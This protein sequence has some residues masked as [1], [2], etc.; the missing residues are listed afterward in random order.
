MIVADTNLIAYLLIPGQKTA[1]AQ[2]VF[3]QDPAWIAPFLWRS[4]FRNVLALYMRQSQLV[5]ADALLFMEA[6]ETLLQGCEYQV[7][8]MPVLRLAERSG[9]AAYDCEFV[10]L[11]QELGIPLLTFDAKLLKVFPQTAMAPERFAG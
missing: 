1:L 3:Q 6:A 4:E 8:S 7:E 2:A 10:Q 9:C 5:L 11:A